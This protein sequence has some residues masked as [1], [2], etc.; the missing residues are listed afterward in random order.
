[1]SSLGVVLFLLCFLGT[2]ERVKPPVNQA[3]FDEREPDNHFGKMTNGGYYALPPYIYS[4]GKYC[5]SRS[6]FITLSTSS[7]VK[8]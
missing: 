1:M 7:V 3:L 6:P 5:A 4:L 2:K 8:I